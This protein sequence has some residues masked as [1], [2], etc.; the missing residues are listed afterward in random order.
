MMWARVIS[1]AICLL[2]AT[3]CASH[4]TTRFVAET[5]A[6]LQ[7]EGVE[8]TSFDF[9]T[10]TNKL[11]LP[12]D[13]SNAGQLKIGVQRLTD[14]R[15]LPLNEWVTLQTMT[16]E[17]NRLIHTIRLLNRR[18]LPVK[19]FD[20]DPKGSCLSYHSEHIVRKRSDPCGCCGRRQGKCGAAAR[21]PNPGGG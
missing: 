14:R 8:V 13:S 16:R 2:A 11:V 20:Y 10:T 15:L 3:G 7:R 12:K 21:D 17:R 6:K 9:D 18:G 4:G 1:G 19:T 5:I